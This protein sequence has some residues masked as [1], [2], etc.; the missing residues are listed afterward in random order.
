MARPGTVLASGEL[1]IAVETDERFR[2][3]R[4]RARKVRDI[5]RVDVCRIERV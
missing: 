4:I 5:G 2:V 1:G 3:R